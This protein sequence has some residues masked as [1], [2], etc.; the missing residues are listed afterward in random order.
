MWLQSYM[1]KYF[2]SLNV[3]KHLMNFSFDFIIKEIDA[4]NYIFMI[5]IFS[6][7]IF[8]HVRLLFLLIIFSATFD[9]IWF[10]FLYVSDF[11]AFMHLGMHAFTQFFRDHVL[12]LETLIFISFEF[13]LQILS[14]IM[15]LSYSF[16]GWL[17]HSEI[18]LSSCTKTSRFNWR[19][20]K[21]QSTTTS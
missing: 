8:T 9:G 3:T 4:W 11:V 6:Y 15:N 16:L 10:R 19:N 13:R 5:Q 18:K 17:V 12:W 1:I 14:F 21:L 7:I 2:H 20:T